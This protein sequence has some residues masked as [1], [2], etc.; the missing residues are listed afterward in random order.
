VDLLKVR[1]DT[2]FRVKRGGKRGRFSFARGTFYGGYK[3]G[4]GGV[5]YLKG[6]AMWTQKKASTF[7]CLSEKGQFLC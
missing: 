2:Y 4:L 1:S 7:L 3:R 5:V 6:S